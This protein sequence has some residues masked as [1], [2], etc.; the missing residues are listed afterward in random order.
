MIFFFYLFAALAVIGALGVISYKN[1]VTSAF[2]MV[3]SFLGIAALF[4]Q[5]DAYLVGI[6]QILV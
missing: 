4:I 2:S 6:L 3:V 5:M 1:P